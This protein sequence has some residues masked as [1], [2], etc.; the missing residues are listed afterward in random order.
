MVL[1]T[2][3]AR[4]TALRWLSPLALAAACASGEP[5]DVPHVLA[6][7]SPAG[8]TDV[9]F[10][11]QPAAHSHN[12]RVEQLIDRA[13]RT[14]DVAMYSFSDAGVHDALAAAV[15]RGVEVRLLLD[16][17]SEDRKLTGAA[18][19]TSKSGR[20]EQAGVDVHWV[21]KIMHHKF[22]IVDGP[23]DA[24]AA[25]DL[26]HL[27]SGSANWSHGGATIYDENTLFMQGQRELVLRMQQEFEHLWTH[28]RDFVGDPDLASRPSKLVIDDASIADDPA[29]HAYFTSANFDVRGGDTFVATGRDEIGDA[30]VAAIEGATSSIYLASGHLRLRPVADALIA[31]AAHHPELDLRVYLDGQEFI[32]EATHQ[33]QVDALADCLAAAGDDSSEQRACNDRGYRHGFIVGASGVPVRY[34]YYAY[35]WHASYAEQMHHKYMI[36]DGDELWTGSFNLSGNAEHNTFENMLMFR[37]PEHA[38]LVARFEDNFA[39]IWET[40]RGDG[41]LAAL[42]DAIAEGGAIPLVFPAM[43]LTHAEIDELKDRIRDACPA[44]NAPDFREHPESHRRCE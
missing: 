26:A 43:A 4:F 44:V 30:L 39:E 12:K 6:R 40:G 5:D 10:S 41:R 33:Q 36:V 34:K 31:K 35:R 27:V 7:D 13:E 9:I 19:Q 17:A 16:T 29:T 24:L 32:A 21:N 2:F 11:P 22:M 8:S 14:L 1:P 42:H 38:Q 25:A 15:E 18:L 37:G 23:R 28:S 3:T 20:L